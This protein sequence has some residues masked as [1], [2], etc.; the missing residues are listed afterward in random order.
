MHEPARIQ[1]GTAMPN[2][3]T[4]KSREE[5][6][7]TI[8]TLWAYAS[9]GQ[10]MPAPVGVKEKKNYVLIVTD[11][12]VMARAQIPDPAGLIVYGISVGLPEGVNYTFDARGVMLRTAWRGG[13]LDM[14]GDWD[15]RGGNPVRILGK[16]FY[17]QAV[18]PLRVGEADKDSP[19]VFKGYELKEKIPTFI[20][21]VGDAE[22]RE[23]ITALQNGEGI[24]R[25]FE[26]EAGDKPVYFVVSD[27]PGVT[28][29]LPKEA[30]PVPKLATGSGQVLQIAGKGKVTFS[31]VVKAK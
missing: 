11:T 18:A 16:R 4:D 22:V 19:R 12:P 1:P 17:S 28:L 8:E 2:F 24:V 14:S 25:T 9:L 23:R 27:V 3:F 10:S 21:R 29:T 15:G 31:V 6:D 5:A 30:V 13:F 20:Y 26:Y 7:R